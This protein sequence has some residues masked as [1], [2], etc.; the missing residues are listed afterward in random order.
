[1]LNRKRFLILAAVVVI[2]GGALVFKQ[3]GSDSSGSDGGDDVIVFAPVEKRTLQDV[4]TVKG[5]VRHEEVGTLNMLANGRVTGINV[6]E[7]DRVSEG[8]PVFAID[9]RPAIAAKGDFPFWR[10]L[11]E[12]S[13]G[14]DVY[15]LEQILARNGYNPGTVD[16]DF[17]ST[18][19]SAL[20]RWQR[21]HRYSSTAKEPDETVMVQLQQMGDGYTVGNEG[22]AAGMIVEQMGG[23]APSAAGSI[24]SSRPHWAGSRLLADPTPKI[25]I[26]ASPTKVVEAEASRLI[27]TS[28]RDATAELTIGFTVSGTATPG[29]DYDTLSGEVKLE[30]GESRVE[31]IVPTFDDAGLESDETIIATLSSGTGYLVG[32]TSQV[33]ITITDETIAELTIDPSEATVTEGDTISIDILADQ[34]LLADTQVELAIGGDAAGGDPDDLGP[35]EDI[36]YV[37]LDDTLTIPAGSA[38]ATLRLETLPDSI[39][40]GDEEVTI[41]I[42]A[43]SFPADAYE[44]GDVFDATITIADDANVPTLT[45]EEDSETTAEGLPATFTVSSDMDFSGS[46]DVYFAVGGAVTVDDDYPEPDETFSFSGSDEVTLSI[47]TTDDDD[48]ELDEDLWVTLLPGEDYRLGDRM[49]AMTTIES[50]DAPELSITGG[51]TVAEGSTMSF[52]VTADKPPAEDT[53]ILFSTTGTAQMGADYEALEGVAVLPTGATSLTINVVT[54]DDD[55]RLQPGDF[56]VGD[57]PTRVGQVSA[58]QGQFLTEGLEIMQLTEDELTVTVT[59]SPSDRAELTEDLPATVELAATGAT[60]PGSIVKLDDAP[61]VSEGGAETYSGEVAVEGELTVVDGATVNVDVVLEEAADAIV[62]P[63]A[64]LVDVGGE[65]TVRVV[66]ADGSLRRAPVVTG[67]TEGAFVEVKEGL[68]GNEQVVV[69]VKPA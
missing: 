22:L 56:V 18:T 6:E 61:D 52:T 34:P 35:D 4:L 36:D 1:M 20:V 60:A 54:I 45:I 38:R 3:A 2:V 53:T 42:T 21:D 66:E 26:A 27:F 31:L 8:D 7:G 55:A 11:E 69:E 62:V 68:E 44:V 15:Q 67:L 16:L 58:D 57:W 43:A 63:V 59:M 46:I 64:S 30:V 37:E 29:D 12:G 24:G 28:D 13:V 10:P 47:A 33:T 32:G 49:A 41:Q 9:G 5:D 23:S 51:G 65:T 50:E 48:I 25:S 40:E 19:R 17:T 14:F 39:V